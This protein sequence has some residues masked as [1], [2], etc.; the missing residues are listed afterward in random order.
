MTATAP[1]VYEL[2]TPLQGEDGKAYGNAFICGPLDQA[3]LNHE[4]TIAV[5]NRGTETWWENKR[6]SFGRLLQILSAFER[7]PKD[8]QCMLQGE[9]VADGPRSSRGMKAMH[10]QIYDIDTGETLEE[11]VN[12]VPEGLCA[13]AWTTHSHMKTES[14]IVEL[15]L[16]KRLKRD[17]PQPTRAEVVA[18]LMKTKNARPEIF[19]GATL[20][21]KEHLAGGVSFRLTHQ[22][23]P[24]V[25][26]LLLLKKPFVFLERGGTHDAA[27]KEW[28]AY[29]AAVAARLGITHDPSC[30][31]PGR[32]FFTPRIPPDAKLATETHAGDAHDIWIVPGKPLDLD[33]I[34][35]PLPA[36]SEKA[37]KP[38]KAAK[39]A[40]AAPA[41]EGFKTANL[42]RFLAIGGGSFRAADWLGEIAPGDIRHDYGDGEKRDCRCPREDSHTDPTQAD[43]GF[44]AI[45]GKGDAGDFQ[46]FC[47]HAGCLAVTTRAGKHDRAVLLDLACEHYGIA[48]AAELLPY[49]DDAAREQ[50]APDRTAPFEE[51][52]TG[53]QR[54]RLFAPGAE[55]W[56]GKRRRRRPSSWKGSSR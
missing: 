13:V 20:R 46:M 47:P 43:R 6:L 24:R 41:D 33:T 38:E 29:Y 37:A 5:G 53:S 40:A 32:L 27:I 48:D 1:N 45:N 7:G 3:I 2:A 44:Y 39:S 14:I 23:W 42:Q 26:L 8:G 54:L 17:I 22:P 36:K 51:R 55:R 50:W 52:Q 19:E 25:R 10:L 34:E 18:D 9:L 28:K 49:C 31:D 56:R 12:R 21:P 35:L 16:M 11:V 30:A 15:P 4:I